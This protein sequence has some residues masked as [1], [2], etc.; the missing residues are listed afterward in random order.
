MYLPTTDI[1]DDWIIVTPEFVPLNNSWS[2][3]KHK[4]RGY[5]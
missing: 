1:C 5:K 2:Q 4:V 3:I